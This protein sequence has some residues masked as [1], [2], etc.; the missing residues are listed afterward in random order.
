MTAERILKIT[1]GPDAG[2]DIELLDWSDLTFGRSSKCDVQLDDRFCSG[3][4]LRIQASDH[5]TIAIDLQSKNG[6]LVNWV[7]ITTATLDD[8]DTIKLGNTQM[9]LLEN[10][11]VEAMHYANGIADQFED[12]WTENSLQ[13]LNELIEQ[14]EQQFRAKTIDALVD[15]DVELRMQSGLTVSPD[16]YQLLGKHAVDRAQ[17]LQ[18]FNDN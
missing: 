17:R 13:T 7:K 5:Q 15:V 4:H 1:A 14:C 6:V 2:R 8:R 10:R 18:R 16:I 9:Q 3:I 12:D 11:N